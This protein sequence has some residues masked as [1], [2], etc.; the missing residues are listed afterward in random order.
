MAI[1]TSVVRSRRN[2]LTGMLGAA[3]AAAAATLAR[4]SAAIAAGDDGQVIHVGDDFAHIHSET[5]LRN[6][7]NDADIL[8]ASSAA[9][10]IGVRGQSHSYTGVQGSSDTA[11][12]VWGFSGSGNGVQGNSGSPSASGVYG[13]H[14]GWGNGV[15]GRSNARPLGRNGVYAAAMLGDNTANGVGVWARSAHGVGLFAEGLNGDAVAIYARG[16]VQFTRSGQLIVKA[17][18]K[19]VTKTGL[20]I[21][22]GTLVLAALQQNRTGVWVQSAVPSA[23]G[24]SFT[25]RLNKSVAADTRVAWFLVN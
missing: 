18:T 5:S 22:Q 16:I 20:R 12:G 19:A 21:D 24:S 4:A 25:I 15:A 2:L 11:T 7:S 8:A 13:E 9:G 10:G 1:D 23:T 6:T 17:G 3:G 14:V